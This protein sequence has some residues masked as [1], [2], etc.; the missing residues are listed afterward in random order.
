MEIVPNGAYAHPLPSHKTLVRIMRHKAPTNFQM[1]LMIFISSNNAY[2]PVEFVGGQV[3]I[4]FM[5]IKTHSMCQA[6]SV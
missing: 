2:S 3:L 1:V 6:R 4:I 5:T